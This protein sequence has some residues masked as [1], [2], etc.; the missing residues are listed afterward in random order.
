M[1]GK[2]GYKVTGS[3]LNVYPPMSTYLE[4]QGVDIIQGFDVSQLNANPDEIIIGNVMK[5]G[6]PIIEHILDSKLEYFSGPN[7]FIKIFSG[8]KKLL[9]LLAHMVK[10]PPQL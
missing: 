8:T 2:K 1:L 5:R 9:H 3:D 4:S 10:L 6:M 7:G